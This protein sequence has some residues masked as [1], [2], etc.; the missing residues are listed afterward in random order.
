[1]DQPHAFLQAAWESDE[2]VG[3][4]LVFADWLEERGDPAAEVIRLVAAEAGTA[5]H[6]RRRAARLR[7]LRADVWKSVRRTSWPGMALQGDHEAVSFSR[8]LKA[9]GSVDREGIVVRP[10]RRTVRWLRVALD[11]DDEVIATRDGRELL[12]RPLPP[13]MLPYARAG[14][15]YWSC[16]LAWGDDHF[17]LPEGWQADPEPALAERRRLVEAALGPAEVPLSDLPAEVVPYLACV[18]CEFLCDRGRRARAGRVVPGAH[19]FLFHTAATAW[20]HHLAVENRDSRRAPAR[21]RDMFRTWAAH[22]GAGAGQDAAAAG[23]LVRVGD[24]GRATARKLVW[25]GPGGE[26][27]ETANLPRAGDSLPAGEFHRALADLDAGVPAGAEAPFV[28]DTAERLRALFT[29]R[30][31]GE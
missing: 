9:G 24:D 20:R 26:V 13:E 21:L 17:P 4:L 19:V 7:E 1:M 3:V 23:L 11:G 31:G 30:A 2:E 15:D 18:L 14:G 5:R 25:L 8:R 12:R 29:A 28:A 27:K 6:D 16:C 22:R 10:G